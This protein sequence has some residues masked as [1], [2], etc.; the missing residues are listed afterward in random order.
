[1]VNT[2]G[3]GMFVKRRL[4]R[5]Q[6]LRQNWIVGSCLGQDP[7]LLCGTRYEELKD[8]LFFQKLSLE[9]LTFYCFHLLWH[10]C[11]RLP[12]KKDC[13]W[14]HTAHIATP[15]QSTWDSSTDSSTMIAPGRRGDIPNWKWTPTMCQACLHMLPHLTLTTSPHPMECVLSLLSKERN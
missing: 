4:G 14:P 13:D 8:K 6:I 3:K 12:R 1:M 10:T 2:I 9:R 5:F 15:W 11:F 7:G